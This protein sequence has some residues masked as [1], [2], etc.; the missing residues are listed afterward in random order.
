M[1]GRCT[2]AHSKLVLAVIRDKYLNGQSPQRL[3]G[4]GHT[5]M[6]IKCQDFFK[7][8]LRDQQRASDVED[9][10]ANEVI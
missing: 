9:N 4:L 7:S 1:G 5:E 3:T 6:H 2:E 10:Q 8:Q